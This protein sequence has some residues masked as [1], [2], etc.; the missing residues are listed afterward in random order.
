[1][2]DKLWQVILLFILDLKLS[3]YFKI[4]HNESGI[5]L[6]EL[7][8]SVI[9]LEISQNNFEISEDIQRYL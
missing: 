8:I 6:N 5:S 1:M 7:K 3:K 4:S 2:H 9:K